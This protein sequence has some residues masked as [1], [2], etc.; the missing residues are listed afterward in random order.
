MESLI[1]PIFRN[2]TDK[3]KPKNMINQEKKD[4]SHKE[5]NQIKPKE[6]KKKI[7]KK[8]TTY[9]GDFESLKNLKEKLEKEG[10]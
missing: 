5:N 10:K 4:S 7:V 2:G 8:S 1:H 3:I 9:L 6:N